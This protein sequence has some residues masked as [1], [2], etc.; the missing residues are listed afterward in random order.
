MRQDNLHVYTVYGFYLIESWDFG[1]YISKDPYER[2]GCFDEINDLKLINIL[3][4]S[5]NGIIR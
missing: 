5:L 1:I 4:F 2:G 3:D